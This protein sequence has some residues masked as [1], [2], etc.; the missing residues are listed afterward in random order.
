MK[1]CSKKN[2]K[3][4]R[5][6]AGGYNSSLAYTGRPTLTQSN[7]FLAYTG[8]GGA[9]GIQL[10]PKY[11]IM[12]P[13][14]NLPTNPYGA[15][16]AL[17]NTGPVSLG[18]STIPT[19]LGAMQKGGFCGA[20]TNGVMTG[21]SCGCQ[22]QQGGKTLEP[23]GLAGEP[24]GT[25]P[26]LWPG[27]DGIG[28]NRNYLAHNNYKVDPQTAIINVGPNPPFLYGGRRKKR[29]NRRTKRRRQRGGNLSNLLSQDFI[30]LGRQ[31]QYN[32]GSTYNAINGYSA[33]KPVLPWQG[34]LPNTPNL[35]TIKGAAL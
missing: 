25:R 3:S 15:N 1:G 14:M 8:K 2:K 26:A 13:N 6:L 31:I 16:P 32:M 17:P 5:S 33:P 29:T 22:K 27:V 35:N 23:Q 4:R 20:C 7:P 19:N 10:P 21:G 28:G 11:D 34:Q 24:W 12:N 9:S 18:R 30:N